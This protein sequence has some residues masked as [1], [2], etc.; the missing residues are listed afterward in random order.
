MIHHGS[1]RRPGGSGESKQTNKTMLSINQWPIRRRI[2]ILPCLFSLG[3]ILLLLA[4]VV[5]ERKLSR[6]VIFPNYD[7]QIIAGHKAALKAL[8][9]SQAIALGEKIRPL[10][11]R[12]EKLA[13]IITATDP[14]RFFDND[15]GYFFT[16]QLDGVR[17]N[18]PV[19]QTDNGK[20]LLDLVDANGVRIVEDFIARAKE[21]G[22]FTEYNYD[23]PGK[24]VQPKL[25][26]C[27]LIPGTDVLVGTGVYI[28]DVKE[29]RLA[30]EEKIN[31]SSERFMMY[32]LAAFTV[33]LA[34]VLVASVLTARAISKTIARVIANLLDGTEQVTA[35]A[36]QVSSS[37]QSLAEGASEQ[38]ASL[39]ETGASLEELS[40]M[41]K[42]NSENA[43]KANDIAKQARGAA[44]K[45]ASDMQAM[46]VAMLDIK[47]SSDDIA[48]II[49]TIDEIAFQTNILAL[50]AAV[51]AARAGEAGS[52]FAVVADEVRSLAQRSALAAKETAAKIE[53]AIGKTAQGVQISGKVALALNEIVAKAR[54]VDE[55]ASEVATAS[56]EQTAGISHI[57]TA[58]AQM[59]QVT[60]RNA[61]G[62]EES[63]AASEQLHAQAECMKQ[64]VGELSQL[65]DG[66]NPAVLPATPTLRA[67]GNGIPGYPLA[68]PP[69][70]RERNGHASLLSSPHRN[71][72]P[73]KMPRAANGVIAWDEPTMATGVES[74]NAS[75]NCTRPVSPGPPKAICL[76]CSIMSARTPSPTSRTRKKS[77]RNTAVL[78]AGRTRPRTRIS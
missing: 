11:S 77:C 27:K 75:T 9:D 12:E 64:S 76:Q 60:Q 35:A 58:V 63:A 67:N 21:G 4:N 69:A 68:A 41:T 14:I 38:A 33:L 20:N 54:Q 13:A 36:G 57:N 28:D 8:V 30:L 55:L 66:H 26:Y 31:R 19:N 61:A 50:N 24:G 7:L 6:Q 44:D 59:K 32:K 25:S 51:E 34:I 45:G 72:S 71:G 17:V 15:S 16:Y 42:R 2:L 43:Q 49:K 70:A 3:F 52:G 37:S 56:R 73:A 39:E 29:E 62:A 47:G 65:V 5:L 18:V 1:L 53:G 40:S 78:S 74:V 46:S 48:K 10:A 23:K 22:G